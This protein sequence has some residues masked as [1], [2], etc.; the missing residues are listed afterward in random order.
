MGHF[1]QSPQ[2]MSSISEAYTGPQI[3]SWASFARPSNPCL[4][5][6]RL[7][8]GIRDN[9]APVQLGPAS[10]VFNFSVLY[11]A[12]ETAMGQFNQARQSMYS[13]SESY[14]EPQRQSYSTLTWPG[15]QCFQLFRIIL[16]LRDNHWQVSP[17]QSIHV[18]NF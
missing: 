4:Q 5:F 16:G 10:H 3:P 13:V 17:C 15:S 1:T 2:S 8:L 6:L 12:S 18:F 11:W 7:I 9:H 14:S